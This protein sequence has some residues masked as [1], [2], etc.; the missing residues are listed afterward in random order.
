MNSAEILKSTDTDT[1]NKNLISSDIDL[2]NKVKQVI[3]N[4]TNER[5][6]HLINFIQLQVI[7]LTGCSND[8]AVTT[9]FDS[10]YNIEV[11]IDKI[12]DQTQRQLVSGTNKTNNDWKEVA[13]NKKK[14]SATET[15][16][17]ESNVNILECI[18]EFFDSMFRRNQ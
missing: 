13:K 16:G 4:I 12:F 1:F 3:F 14:Q 17:V 9:L 2:L 8:I 5:I 15:S 7:E 10:N 6:I 11:A 18:Y